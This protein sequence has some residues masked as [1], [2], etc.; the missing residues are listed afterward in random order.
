MF[1]LRW[2][3]K[4]C[5]FV[6]M[7]SLNKLRF[8]NYTVDQN[9]LSR[10]HDIL[11][12]SMLPCTSSITLTNTSFEHKSVSTLTKYLYLNTINF[13]WRGK[14]SNS[15]HTFLIIWTT[16][17]EIQLKFTRIIFLNSLDPIPRPLFKLRYTTA[18]MTLTK[19]WSYDTTG[20]LWQWYRQVLVF[21]FPLQKGWGV[22]Q[23]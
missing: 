14:K 20:D 8:N 10:R 7:W 9:Y 2:E 11:I 23:K 12:S 22:T 1:F 3:T 6:K 19:T 18:A 15:L 16:S 4:S 13:H 17:S 21:C 5:I